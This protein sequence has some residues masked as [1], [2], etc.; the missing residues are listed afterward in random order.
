MGSSSV[1][2]V[3]THVYECILSSLGVSLGG[4]VRVNAKEL[5]KVG[6]EFKIMGAN[7][8]PDS[9]SSSWGSRASLRIY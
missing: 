1:K 4:L 8:Q 3:E 5:K 7:E 9:R 6:T 2:L